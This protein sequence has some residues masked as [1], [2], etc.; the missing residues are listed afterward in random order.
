[1][2]S[3]THK[4]IP[5]IEYMSISSAQP[6]I[7]SHRAVRRKAQGVKIPHVVPDDLVGAKFQALICRRKRFNPL[8]ARQESR[9]PPGWLAF[10]L[11]PFDQLPVTNAVILLLRCELARPV[12][13]SG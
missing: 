1:M 5:V 12:L 11:T 9:F 10:S 4:R 13:P 3:S 7:Q 8:W 6:E 2:P